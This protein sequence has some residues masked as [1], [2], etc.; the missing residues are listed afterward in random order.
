MHSLGSAHTIAPSASGV[1]TNPRRGAQNGPER[2]GGER[3]RG[4]KGGATASSWHSPSG[5]A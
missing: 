3:T 5:W 4:L 2:V 1:E